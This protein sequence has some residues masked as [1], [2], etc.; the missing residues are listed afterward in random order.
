M[1]EVLAQAGNSIRTATRGLGRSIGGEVHVGVR[2]GGQSGALKHWRHRDRRHSPTY[3]R[4]VVRTPKTG[5]HRTAGQR[6][7]EGPRHTLGTNGRL[8]G[9]RNAVVTLVAVASHGRSGVA[10]VQRPR[11][12]DRRGRYGSTSTK[13]VGGDDTEG[14]LDVVVEARE[15]TLRRRRGHARGGHWGVWEDRDG[16]ADDWL[17]SV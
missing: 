10:Q 9:V 14:V 6:E 4:G 15:Q 8:G 7:A 12:W 5:E 3:R 13:G 17:T 11:Q 16:V 1:E 2:A